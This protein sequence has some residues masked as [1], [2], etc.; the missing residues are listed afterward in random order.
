MDV[1]YHSSKGKENKRHIFKGVGGEFSVSIKKD[2]WECN[3][4]SKYLDL[5]LSFLEAKLKIE[6]L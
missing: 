4:K 3:T 1:L 6:I 5:V 2:T